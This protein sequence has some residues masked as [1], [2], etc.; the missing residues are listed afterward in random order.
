[1]RFLTQR[2]VEV[3]AV[4]GEQMRE[5]D[6][7]AITGT[8]PTVPQ[9][10]ENAGRSLASVAIRAL[11]ERWRER[12]IVILAGG[13]GNGGGGICA[14]RHLMNHG[15]RVVLVRADGHRH[16]DA[17]RSQLALYHA[18][19]GQEVPASALGSVAPALIID[20]LVGYGLVD[21]PRG[22]VA[23]LIQWANALPAS[24][25]SLDL[26]SGIDATTGASPGVALTA[27]TTLTLALPK[28]GL[29]ARQAGTLRLA[30]IGIPAG[31]YGAIG[32]SYSPPFGR[33]WDIPLRRVAT[34]R[35][36]S[37]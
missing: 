24:T 1:M 30:D 4:S 32:L 5:I 19:G 35:E 7:I 36:V 18:A 3:P 22:E 28:L 23:D 17:A 16:G 25:L 13:G 33:E 6:R 34:T 29:C 11:G 26:P 37:V 9:M 15:A 27:H 21:P 20:A 10:M 14:G 12:A 8:G 31:V 2:G